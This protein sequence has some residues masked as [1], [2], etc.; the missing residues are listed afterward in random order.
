LKSKGKEKALTVHGGAKK[1]VLAE[2]IP[3]SAMV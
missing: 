1:G 3:T 2:Y